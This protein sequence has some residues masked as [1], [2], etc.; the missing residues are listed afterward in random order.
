M[1]IIS[2]HSRPLRNGKRNPKNFPYW[3]EV[4]AKLKLEDEVIQIGVQGEE[5]LMKNFKSGLPFS[6]IEN[7]VKECDFWLSVDNFLPHLAHHFK[8]PGVAVWGVSDPIIFG[9]PE[10]LNI[11]KDRNLL[12]K[13]QYDMWENVEFNKDV[14][15][16]IDEVVKQI[17][18]FKSKLI[19]K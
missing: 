6:E 16:S 14:F 18:D 4:I 13:N 1:I 12:R 17:E 3:R 8:K 19:I 10:N 9:Y 15:P 5:I 11:L 2:P 7:M